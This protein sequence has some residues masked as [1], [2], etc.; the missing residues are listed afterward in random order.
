MPIYFLTETQKNE[1]GKK[2][3]LNTENKILAKASALL[4]TALI[5]PI[6]RRR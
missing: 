6:L 5:E 1:R 2:L 3:F 4:F